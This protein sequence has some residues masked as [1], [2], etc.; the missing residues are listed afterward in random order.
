MYRY[1]IGDI[2]KRAIA[3]ESGD[4][5][6][7]RHLLKVH[8]FAS[9]IGHLE[10]LSPERQETLEAAA[11]LHDLVE[12][13][14]VDEHMNYL[15]PVQK[16]MDEV[17]MEKD[18]RDRVLFLI[19]RLMIERPVE[20]ADYQILREVDFLVEACEK[21]VSKETV[22]Q[23]R[24]Q[25]FKTP[26]SI[27]LINAM[28]DLDSQTDKEHAPPVSE[29][30]KREL[31]GGSEILTR[32]KSYF[33]LLQ[34]NM[35]GYPII[36]D[37]KAGVAMF[38]AKMAEDF[39]LPG[40]VIED[41]E[42]AYNHKVYA[43]DRAEF[44][45]AVRAVFVEQTR[46]RL[47]IEY[48]LKAK[49]GHYVWLWDRGG[50]HMDAR[51]EPDF[52]AG[53]ITRMDRAIYADPV[54]GLLNRYAFEKDMETT[55]QDAA[56]I[57]K[58][59]AVM[60]IGLDD[61][62]LLTDN[63][64]QDVGDLAM[65]EIARGIKNVLPSHLNLY[66]LD[67]P[68]FTLIWPDVSPEEVS[69][70]FSGIQICLREMK[71]AN[72][73]V[74]FSASAGVAFYPDHGTNPHALMKYARAALK[75]AQKNQTEHLS[76]FSQ[77]E[78]KKYQ[79]FINLQRS[80]EDSIEKGCLGFHLYFQPQ[81]DAQT[82]KLIGAEALLRWEEPDGQ[83]ISPLVFIP[84]LERTRL[85]IPVGRWVATEAIKTC[86]KWQEIMPGFE[87]SINVSLCQL[88]TYDLH[89]CV[90]EA[91]ELY[92]LNPEFLTLELTESQKVTNWEFVNEQFGKFQQMGVHV[93]MDDFGAG[94]STLAMLKNFTCD[95]VK[96]DKVFVDDLQES[97]FGRKLI[98]YTTQL[99]HSLGM[100]VCVEGVEE[101]EA[102]DYLVKEC[103][104]DI[105]QGF[106]FGHPEPEALFV[107]SF[108]D[109]WSDY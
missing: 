104:V 64:S 60:V 4:K 1:E 25:M 34:E 11:I 69:I 87:M 68:E 20:A 97:E 9:M 48:R 56:I 78:Y 77:Q 90:K 31:L 36:I 102:Y 53:V 26:C 33:D 109:M 14:Q 44:A 12:R 32:Y 71:E 15:K 37:L 106:Y 67:G 43:E 39:D 6:R 47:D 88:E 92:D 2:V 29:K 38:S 75:M 17:G 85:I 40:T 59:G 50:M 70:I 63:F 8:E 58:Q 99:C 27:D 82:Q 96:V 66:K 105:I 35:D 73:D 28:F 52:F 89:S 57:G 74:L 95:I 55:M 79:D 3:F 30:T 84:I 94:H 86:K 76:F 46:T 83:I 101:K 7:I 10:K 100:T 45:A 19:H 13:S 65:R 103:E 51:G 81:V 18:T 41:W 93:A 61:F 23:A 54:T 108:R 21:M 22:R 16:I 91:L 72:T 62:Q 49:D 80:F 107:Q 5:H 98:K 42:G 24:D